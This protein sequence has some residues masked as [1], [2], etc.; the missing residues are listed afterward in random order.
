MDDF[1][2]QVQLPCSPIVSSSDLIASVDFAGNQTRTLC[3]ASKSQL[4]A[5][6]LNSQ[7]ATFDLKSSPIAIKAIRAPRNIQRSND[8]EEVLVVAYASTVDL[9]TF[10]GDFRQVLHYQLNSDKS[11]ITEEQ[12]VINEYMAQTITPQEFQNRLKVLQS[13][14]VLSE[15]AQKILSLPAPGVT[16]E[17]YPN[18]QKPV[19]IRNFQ[20][21]LSSNQEDQITCCAVLNATDN[22]QRQLTG[23]CFCYCT[24]S[25]QFAIIN[26]EFT[27]LL[28]K[29]SL[30]SAGLQLQVEGVIQLDDSQRVNNLQLEQLPQV[31][32]NSWRAT[33]FTRRF[34]V[35]SI[36]NSK[37][38]N[39][40]I[41]EKE[42]GFSYRINKS[43]FLVQDT[44]KKLSARGRVEQE[45]KLNFKPKFIVSVE[46][47]I[48]KGF[49]GFAVFSESSDCAFFNEQGYCKQLYFAHQNLTGVF[50][51]QMQQAN[52]I[53]FSTQAGKLFYR[54]ISRTCDLNS[55]SNLD[56]RLA[57]QDVKFD[58]EYLDYSYQCDSLEQQEQRM[59]L[60]Q[61][62]RLSARNQILQE[63]VIS[64]QRLQKKVVQ[65]LDSALN[66]SAYVEGA[67][68]FT[69][70]LE[71]SNPG[72]VTSNAFTAS[73]I[74]PVLE[75]SQET[76]FC[77]AVV[78]GRKSQKFVP[79]IGRGS[80]GELISAHEIMVEFGIQG[81]KPVDVV[82]V[83]VPEFIL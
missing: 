74:S 46:I 52:V 83:Q 76:V 6:D 72:T 10:D 70:V 48:G 59:R 79:L 69:L 14:S 55:D 53:L 63:L 68:P 54:Q 58:V 71:V 7:I 21:L 4:Q 61:P 8:Q 33:I 50:I 27:Q 19:I 28:F 82:W 80:V 75:A 36:R 49:T 2:T 17:Q 44:V 73:I 81:G 31:Q 1:Q 51:G 39:N 78:G 18:N 35:V 37:V 26:P 43:V 34:E 32:Q 20:Q 56:G 41:Y 42:C 47:T 67:G 24:E 62:A 38:S 11:E 30:S 45:W 9:F 40:Q 23:Q 5:F 65:T 57:Q 16:E 13:K 25:A 12:T 60:F 64:E 66:F 29:C 77:S 3:V 15:L 22:N